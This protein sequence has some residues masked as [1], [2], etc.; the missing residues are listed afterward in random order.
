MSTT[1]SRLARRSPEII[2][3][4]CLAAAVAGLIAAGSGLTFFFDEWQLVLD[5]QG[6]SADVF[7]SPHNGQVFVLPVAAYKL[8]LGIFGMGSQLPFRIAAVLMISLCSVLL[9][10]YARRRVGPWMALVCTVPLLCLG[11]AWEALLLPL[12]INFTACLAAGLGML[13]ALERGDRRGDIAATVLLGISIAAGGLG[14]AFAAGAAVNVAVGRDLR[15]APIVLA[16][17]S[18]LVLWTLVYGGEGMALVS[19]DRVGEVGDS[20]FALLSTALNSLAGLS[21]D[22]RPYFWLSTDQSPGLVLAVLFLIAL[23]VR[24][25]ITRVPITRKSLE[26]GAVLLIFWL[27]IAI[28]EGREPESSRYQY[29][30]AVLLVAFVLSLLEGFRLPRLLPLAL[31]PLVVLSVWS[32]ELA[33]EGGRDFL[34]EQSEVTLSALGVMEAEDVR[35]LPEFTAG[36]TRGDTRFLQ[37]IESGPYFR[38]ID[39]EGVTLGYDRRRIEGAPE[40][41]RRIAAWVGTR[42]ETARAGRRKADP[43]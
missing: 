2:F 15:R 38:A 4:I 21:P 37:F 41:A 36:D 24:L 13:L 11:S 23:A 43:G 3:G 34:L 18:L 9:F 32:S 35:D 7:L 22:R 31:V 29:P 6:I 8:L 42:I 28:A 40:P 16:P 10:I 20:L 39:R 12:S 27:L 14:L 26:V 19:I 17:V 30:G 33:L 1:A 5:R 25:A